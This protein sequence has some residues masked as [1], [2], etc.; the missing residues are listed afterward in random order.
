MAENISAEDEKE[1]DPQIPLGD[2]RRVSVNIKDRSQ[3][4]TEM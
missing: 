2:E 4:L 3:R 1:I